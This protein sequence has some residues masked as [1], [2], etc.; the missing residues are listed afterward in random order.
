VYSSSKGDAS[1]HLN[2][3]PLEKWSILLGT[4]VTI[5]VVSAAYQAVMLVQMLGDSVKKIVY[6]DA[7]WAGSIS[8]KEMLSVQVDTQM[9][10]DV[11]SRKT[12]TRV[13]VKKQGLP[14]HKTDCQEHV[15]VL[16][17]VEVVVV[18][19]VMLLSILAIRIM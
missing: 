12:L 15:R 7:V 5:M 3:V 10:Q 19:T 6:L 13:Q 9:L 14:V 4:L 11:V 18:F 17:V 16:V 1:V 8:R 2:H